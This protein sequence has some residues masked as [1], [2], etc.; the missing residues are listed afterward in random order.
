[1]F[2]RHLIILLGVFWVGAALAT[3]VL[4][5]TGSDGLSSAIESAQ[6]GD[7]LILQSGTYQGPVTIDRSLTLRALNR[8]A[9]PEIVAPAFVIDGAGIEVEIQGIDFATPVTINRA[10]DVKLLENRFLAGVSIL[11]TNYKTS[12]GDGTL[13]IIGNRLDGGDITGIY[14]VDA[15]IAGNTLSEGYI[16]VYVPA[17]I[18]G[19]Q[20]IGRVFDGTEEI[21]PVYCSGVNGKVR[22]LSN[23]IVSNAALVSQHSANRAIYVRATEAIIAGNIIQMKGLGHNSY[24]LSAIHTHS[25]TLA[26]VV[27]NVIDGSELSQMYVSSAAIYATGWISG[28]IIVDF[29]RK[30]IESGAGSSVG[31]N[32]C[33]G[34]GTDCSPTNGNLNADPLFVDRVDYRLNTGDPRSPAIDA[35]PDFLTTAD[36]DRTRNDIGAYGGPWSI[37]QYDAQRDPTY[38]G[39]L[40][41]PLV[42][43]STGLN[44]ETLNIRALGV[45]RLR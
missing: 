26:Q 1:M 42:E 31:N 8:A 16:T 22:I 17:W 32:L 14:S 39:P 15:F 33:F 28:N 35:G 34:N 4:V 12:Q 3:E 38:A 7:T 9:R 41:F 23:R 30:A 37:G 6:S 36:L 44:A 18:V 29:Q 43:A 5:P 2:E 25:A 20:I 21:A 10:A 40:V 24:W 19:N 27:N 45:A 11:A 13:S